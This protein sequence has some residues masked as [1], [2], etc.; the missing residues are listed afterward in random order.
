MNK[1]NL[2]CQCMVCNC[3]IKIIY[4][5]F[6]SIQHMLPQNTLFY[7]R[8]YIWIFKFFLQE[9]LCLVHVLI[10]NNKSLNLCN[11][12]FIH[13]MLLILSLSWKSNVLHLNIS[14][15]FNNGHFR[16]INYIFSYSLGISLDQIM[17]KYHFH[18]INM[19]N[20][21]LKFLL[22]SNF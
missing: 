7:I 6:T 1:Y 22:L 8:D 2:Y 5:I 17:H 3:L 11:F 21:I 20:H 18:I 4:N 10:K 16:D 14:Y 9:H 13:I 19:I 12:Q 15:P